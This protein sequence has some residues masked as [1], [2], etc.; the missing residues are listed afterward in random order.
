MPRLRRFRLESPAFGSPRT[1]SNNFYIQTYSTGSCIVIATPDGGDF[2]VFLDP[3]CADEVIAQ[4]YFGRSASLD[5]TFISDDKATAYLVIESK[6][7]Q[8]ELDKLFE[9]DCRN[10]NGSIGTL[11]NSLGMTFAYISPGRFTMGSP[12]CEPNRQEDESQHLVT[13]TQ[14]FYMQTTEVTQGQWK[15][16]MGTNPSGFD[17]CGDDCPVENVSWDDIQAFIVQLNSLGDGVYRLPTEAEW[18][19]VA[20]AGSALAFANGDI[21]AVS[22]DTCELDAHL[23]DVG[24]YCSNSG[25]TTHSV[26]KKTANAWGLYDVYGNVWEW[27][28]DRYGTYPPGSAIDPTGPSTGLS[29][30]VR[31]GSWHNAARGCRS[32]NRRGVAPDARDDIFGVRLV[33]SYP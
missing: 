23:E 29:Q 32:A 11:T 1:A 33:R 16:V 2:H 13:L 17:T 30:V 4:E 20:R 14:G 7:T 5:L 24:W 18:E 21:V 28:E 9:G 8:Y 19:Y 12:E 3:Q 27:C 26:A 25:D 31:G 22:P 6:A 15:A 10:G